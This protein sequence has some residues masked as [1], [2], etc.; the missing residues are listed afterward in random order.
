METTTPRVTLTGSDDVAGSDDAEATGSNMRTDTTSAHMGGDIVAAIGEMV[1]KLDKVSVNT[2]RPAYTVKAFVGAGEDVVAWLANFERYARLQNL[3][4]NQC[5]DA[6]AFHV[7]GIAETWYATLPA[8]LQTEWP[9]LKEACRQRFAIPQHG[10]WRQER[11]LY[12]LRQQP[13]QDVASF[14]AVVLKAARGLEMTQAQLVRLVLGG[15]H[16]TVTPFVEITQPTTVDELLRCPAARNG[17]AAP[18]IERDVMAYD[19]GR[20]T[21]EACVQAEQDASGV[22]AFSGR[23]S[24]DRS[25]SQRGQSDGYRPDNRHGNAQRGDDSQQANTRR[26]PWQQ[27]DERCTA[28]G[29]RWCQGD[30]NCR[31]YSR[32]CFGCNRT[33]HFI[34]Q[35]RSSRR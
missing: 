16:T 3:V 20:P 18:A 13:G 35:C 10:R 17:M 23:Y 12:T 4:G 32:Q 7:S 31:A 6:F 19:S 22:N 1:D 2:A 5:A 25:G 9:A 28:C 26:Q 14:T 27:R 33:G 21:S 8:S 34:S 29:G 24:Q 11:D 15:L 30:R